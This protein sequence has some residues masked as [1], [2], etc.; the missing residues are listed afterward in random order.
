M[1][2][3]VCFTLQ[4]RVDR[5]DEYRHRHRRVWPEMTDALTRAGWNNYSLFLRGDGLLIGYLETDSFD[6]AL[7]RMAQTEVNARWQQQTAPFFSFAEGSHRADEAMAA[8]EEVF[9]LS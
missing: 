6:N 4:V 2:E 5:L 1:T 9:H 7:R 8:V 3:R